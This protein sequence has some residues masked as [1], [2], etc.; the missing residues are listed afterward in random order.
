M[1][2]FRKLG[3]AF[4]KAVEVVG[5]KTKCRWLEEKGWKI[6]SMCE[7]VVSM[8]AEDIGK[9]QG[10][11]EGSSSITDT[12]LI[13]Q[14]L[15]QFTL[16]LETYSDDIESNVLVEVM[17]YF[18]ELVDYLQKSYQSNQTNL[19]VSSLVIHRQKL[20]ERV[21]GSFKSHLAKRV[22]LSDDECMEI[23]KLEPSKKKE[24]LM[25]QFGKKVLTE[26]AT[27]LKQDIEGLLND[28]QAVIENSLMEK[29][30]EMI[31]I[32]E[33][34]MAAFQSL[35]DLHGKESSE[36]VANKAQTLTKLELCEYGLE[37]LN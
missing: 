4:G 2:L 9:V 16:E 26:A 15:S 30:A 21:K 6:Q 31:A 29:M 33:E 8:T 7:E 25:K 34:K 17:F 27:Y 32:Q 37:I 20:E 5:E 18:D 19:N 14:I 11:L 3:R 35:K 24:T 23:L 12:K 1:G 10:Y 22:S 28:Y 13:N 36:H